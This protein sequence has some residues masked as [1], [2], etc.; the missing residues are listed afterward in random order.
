MIPYIVMLVFIIVMILWVVY[1]QL[2]DEGFGDSSSSYKPLVITD[3]TT[4]NEIREESKKR[5]E[6][7]KTLKATLDM[8]TAVLPNFTPQEIGMETLNIVEQK[9]DGRTF[10]RSSFGDSPT[11]LAAFRAL[12][13]YQHDEE[14]KKQTTMPTGVNMNQTY[15][16][17][18]LSVMP[19]QPGTTNQQKEI[20][21]NGMVDYTNKKDAKE[22]ALYQRIL[23]ANKRTTGTTS[24]GTTTTGTTTTG[25]TTTGT[26]ST[27]TTTTGTTQNPASANVVRTTT[28]T[29]Q[30]PASGNVVTTTTGTTQNPASGNVVTT[31]TGTTQNPASANVVRTTTGTTQNPAS[32]NVV[33]STTGTTGTT[34][35]PASGNVVTSTTGTTQNPASANVVR[36]T[37]G[38]TQN[39]ASGNVV[40]STTG[41]T[42]N[43]ASG[44]VV[45]TNT[46]TTQNPASGNV[47][48]STTGTTQNVASGNVVRTQSNFPAL[49]IDRIYAMVGSPYDNNDKPIKDKKVT[50]VAASEAEMNITKPKEKKITDSK[51][52]SAPGCSDN[53][54]KELEYRLA[55]NITKQLRDDMLSQRALSDLRPSSAPCMADTMPSTNLTQQGYEYQ[56]SKPLDMN[57]YIRKDSIPCWGCSLPQ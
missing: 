44:S 24:T 29:T 28:G 17:Y 23:D 4:L 34:Q 48:T 20:A 21:F 41:T 7:F 9:R 52:D 22:F 38:T 1:G 31:T 50:D 27:G 18:V 36:T 15:K 3:K 5:L 56:H 43:P 32:G 16:A 2:R 19:F 8:P 13:K 35:N 46:G 39:P 26:S 55:K 14:Q 57:D 6:F 49:E 53:F 40:T 11:L 42:Q 12:V 30:N 54:S 51:P 37:T 47:V 25:T 33:T 45:R 10:Y